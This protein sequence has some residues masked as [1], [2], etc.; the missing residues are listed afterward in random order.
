MGV[1][2]WTRDITR[3][4]EKP[5]IKQHGKRDFITALE[6]VSADGFAFLSYLIGEGSSFIEEGTRSSLYET[7]Y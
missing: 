5:R 4:G 1:S 2:P 3:R 7:Q 6:A